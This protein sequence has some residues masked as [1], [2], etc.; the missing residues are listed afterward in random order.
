MWKKQLSNS[1]VIGYLV[2][3]EMKKVTKTFFSSSDIFMS[4]FTL[5]T[6]EWDYLFPSFLKLAGDDHTHHI[7]CQRLLWRQEISLWEKKRI[8]K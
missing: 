4:H 8:I 3:V 2:T 5:F 6:Q 7:M 1:D